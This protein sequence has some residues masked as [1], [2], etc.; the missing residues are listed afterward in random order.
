MKSTKRTFTRKSAFAGA[1]SDSEGCD[2]INPEGIV[3]EIAL[4]VFEDMFSDT[5]TLFAEISP[6]CEEEVTNESVLI[7]EATSSEPR[8]V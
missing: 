6:S 8:T 2:L 5:E 3:P 1:A 7:S 4:I